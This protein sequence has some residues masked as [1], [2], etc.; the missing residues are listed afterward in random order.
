M[1]YLVHKNIVDEDLLHNV[2][3]VNK[4]PLSQACKLLRVPYHS[5]QRQAKNLLTEEEYK[6]VQSNRDRKTY[7]I[8]EKKTIIKKGEALKRKLMED[9]SSLRPKRARTF[10]YKEIAEKYE[11]NLILMY[12]WRAKFLQEKHAREAAKSK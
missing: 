6:F 4:T 10:A 3:V 9:D 5:L 8:D 11:I 1:V 2:L 7:T 12:Q